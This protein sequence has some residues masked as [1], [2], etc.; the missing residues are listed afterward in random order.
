VEGKGEGRGIS[1]MWQGGNSVI[2]MG[3]SLTLAKGDFYIKSERDPDPLAS[4]THWQG[5]KIA[6]DRQGLEE[7]K[8]PEMT[9]DPCQ[10][11]D[12]Q[13]RPYIDID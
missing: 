11:P 1:Y 8:K 13:G 2:D 3:L 9:S 12:V 6:I 10:R 4:L 5:Q 7:V